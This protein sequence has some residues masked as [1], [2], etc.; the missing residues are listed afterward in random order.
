[1]THQLHIYTPEY[2]VCNLRT[3]RV[4]VWLSFKRGN[5]QLFQKQ[6][7]RIKTS[8]KEEERGNLERVPAAAAVAIAIAIAAVPGVETGIV[9]AWV[10]GLDDDFGWR[11]D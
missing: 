4:K 6:K 10:T 7:L 3:R 5:R 9:D 2:E 8:I 1:V 11:L